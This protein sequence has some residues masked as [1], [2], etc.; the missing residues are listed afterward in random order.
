MLFITEK[1]IIVDHVK[2]LQK[3]V[4]FTLLTKTK[5]FI[6]NANANKKKKHTHQKNKQTNKPKTNQ[7]IKSK[8]PPPMHDAIASMTCKYKNH[9]VLVTI[10]T[11]TLRQINVY[12]CH[13]TCLI[14][15]SMKLIF[16][17]AEAVI[18]SSIY[19]F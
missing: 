17:E 9:Y 8:T 18:N 12:Y 11:V 14:K 5:M 13:V 7:N 4:I 16:T 2:Y 3:S 10:E 19:S 6:Y 1:K 15:G